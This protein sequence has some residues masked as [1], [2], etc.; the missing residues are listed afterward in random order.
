MTKKVYLFLSPENGSPMMNGKYTSSE[1]MIGVA[2]LG[3]GH[4][5]V[6]S[7]YTAVEGVTAQ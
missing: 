3:A 6:V 4:S 7:S 2:F 5:V 1:V